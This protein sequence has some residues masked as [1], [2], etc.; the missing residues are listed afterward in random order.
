MSRQ[1]RLIVERIDR[2]N[3]APAAQAK[4]SARAMFIRMRARQIVTGALSEF[5]EP[6]EKIAILRALLDIIGE[7][8]WP[9]TTRVDAATAFNAVAA[10]ICAVF[11]LDRGIKNARAEQA[12]AKLTAAAND[13]GGADD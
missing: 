7:K 12:F 9:L 10:D 13:R 2:A 4:R 3:E 5:E 11:R 8:L 6:V 1:E